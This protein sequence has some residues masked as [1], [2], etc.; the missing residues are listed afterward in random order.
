[1]FPACLS[2]MNSTDMLNLR[3]LGSTQV[4]W[5]LT[6]L[7]LYNIKSFTLVHAMLSYVYF[8]FGD[9]CSL[10]R[11]YR[12]NWLSSVRTEW[13][14]FASSIKL[15]ILHDPINRKVRLLT[16]QCWF[17]I[18]LDPLPKCHNEENQ[19][20]A[21]NHPIQTKY[22][23][24]TSNGMTGDLVVNIAHSP[25]IPATHSVTAVVF[26]ANPQNETA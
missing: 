10:S 4:L 2:L 1:M 24:Q 5:A 25:W 26:Q 9:I 13:I 22:T 20:H 14:N 12:Y 18:R 21:L 7:L 3:V 16:L 6:C 19:T 23:Q 17:L 15:V 11:G 8:F